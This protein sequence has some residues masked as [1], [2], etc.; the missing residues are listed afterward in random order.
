MPNSQHEESVLKENNQDSISSASFLL[1]TEALRNLSQIKPSLYLAPFKLGFSV[2]H[3]AQPDFVYTTRA[4]NSRLSE[5]NESIP[6]PSSQK[7]FFTETTKDVLPLAPSFFKEEHFLPILIAT[8]PPPTF[9]VPSPPAPLVRFFWTSEIPG[10]PPTV[11]KTFMSSQTI[12]PG[13][14]PPI[15]WETKDPVA[16]MQHWVSSTNINLLAIACGVGTV[17]FLTRLDAVDK[18]IN[19]LQ[20]IGEK[21]YLKGSRDFLLQEGCEKLSIAGIQR[22]FKTLNIIP[23][24]RMSQ[25][26]E[27]VGSQLLEKN[28]WDPLRENIGDYV[29]QTYDKLTTTP[30]EAYSAETPKTLYQAEDNSKQNISSPTI[31]NTLTLF[32]NPATLPGIEKHFSKQEQTLANIHFLPE[33]PK[34]NS[35]PSIIFAGI[36][37]HPVISSFPNP[38]INLEEYHERNYKQ[39]ADSVFKTEK[40]DVSVGIET[41]KQGKLSW[42]VSTTNPYVGGGMFFGTLL[43]RQI[44]WT[45]ATPEEQAIMKIQHRTQQLSSAKKGFIDRVL[46]WDLIKHPPEVL[47]FPEKLQTRRQQQVVQEYIDLAKLN[48]EDRSVAL[49]AKQLQLVRESNP[50]LLSDLPTNQK[51]IAEIHHQAVNQLLQNFNRNLKNQDT[52]ST[53]K[54]A[55]ELEKLLPPGPLYWQIE[56]CAEELNGNPQQAECSL[57]RACRIAQQDLDQA[58]CALSQHPT[59]VTRPTYEPPSTEI[60]QQHKEAVDALYSMK[61][62]RLQFLARQAKA[63][64]GENQKQWIQIWQEEAKLL[65]ETYGNNELILRHNVDANIINGNIIEAAKYQKI[66]CNSFGKKEDDDRLAKMLF[67]LDDPDWADAQEHYIN[68]SGNY[69]SAPALVE[70]YEK[71]N[72]TAKKKDL[73]KKWHTKDPKNEV[74]LAEL[75]SLY[76][77]EKAWQEAEYY[78]AQLDQIIPNNLDIQR[79]YIDS[80]SQQ[81]QDEKFIKIKKFLDNA[82]KHPQCHPELKRWRDVIRSENFKQAQNKAIFFSLVVYGSYKAGEK[83]GEQTVNAVAAGYNFV[84]NGYY[85]LFGCSAGSAAIPEDVSQNTTSFRKR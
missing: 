1:K 55:Q 35:D 36:L 84:K 42:N 33:L 18:S 57:N 68:K 82:V 56:A 54:S 25:L 76:R 16:D 63:Q 29:T 77:A 61:I 11:L 21:G 23:T 65:K 40:I 52:T 3:I 13:M 58:N 8:P 73:L 34:D 47:F 48:P 2:S 67:H 49:L 26:S 24:A 53:L 72:Q 85:S 64:Q 30:T 38:A 83:A 19:Y 41:N 44:K 17:P 31:N 4:S 62:S 71:Q 60:L 70:Y 20:E 39:L 37:T 22:G 7:A 51:K 80:L 59:L 43:I 12:T 46:S 79:A 66:I 15:A 45:L 74:V 69:S 6:T 78:L 10:Y 32:S 50:E 27:L 28:F 5:N 14:L 75:S 81:D 9:L